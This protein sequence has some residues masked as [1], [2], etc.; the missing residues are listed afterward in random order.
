MWSEDESDYYGILHNVIELQYGFDHL[1]LFKCHWFD[2]T[3]GLRVVHPHGIVEVKH[4][5]TL[6]SSDVFILVSQAQQVYY[7]SY[8][9]THRDRQQWW[10]A[11][12]VRLRREFAVTLSSTSLQDN[13]EYDNVYQDDQARPSGPRPVMEVDVHSQSL[14]DPHILEE[15]DVEEL[16]AQPSEH[17]AEHST[18]DSDDCATYDSDSED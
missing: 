13:E 8:P 4:A 6:A 1:V 14:V 15:V 9:S 11:C 12:K 3:R 5:S 7:M 2:T 18:S 16:H 17:N 10:V